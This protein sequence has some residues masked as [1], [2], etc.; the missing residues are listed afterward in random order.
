MEQ[1][2]CHY[3]E[4]LQSEAEL[5]QSHQP[6]LLLCRQA[7]FGLPEEE[8]DDSRQEDRKRLAAEREAFILD[9]PT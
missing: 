5:F 6:T 1:R 8:P 3:H 4:L 9:E 2:L 7:P